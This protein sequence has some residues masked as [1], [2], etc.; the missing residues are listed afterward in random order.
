MTKSR[1]RIKKSNAYDL[2]FYVLGATDFYIE[3]CEKLFPNIQELALSSKEQ[4]M[5]LVD[6]PS[7]IADRFI[8]YARCKSGSAY[9]KKCLFNQIPVDNDV[10]N[11]ILG[12]NI[13]QKTVS[14][15]N[16]IKS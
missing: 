12:R 6:I 15:Q 9:I 3:I 16:P 7:A 10:L 4:L 2:M 11:S 1:V 13:Y 14:E 8:N 5:E